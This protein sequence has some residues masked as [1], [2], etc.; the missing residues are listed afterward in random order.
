MI[1][2]W[3][4]AA[5]NGGVFGAPLTD[6]S[7]AFDCI[8]HDL[9]IAKLEAYGFHI[10]ASQ[11]IHDYLSNRK[12]RVKVNDAYSSWKDIF[13]GVPQGS[14]LDPFSFDIHLC[15]LFYFLEDFDIASYADDTT[16]YKVS[17][18]EE[19]VI[20]AL[21]TSSSL[22]FGWFNNNFMKANSDKSN[23]IMSCAEAS[24]AV[25]DG[26]PI[27]SS[28]TEVLLGITIDH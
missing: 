25:I 13:Y 12:Q 17:E 28:K 4:K 16:I 24:A 20:R 23:L 19:S 11:L 1:E 22:L 8:P 6:L 21:E 10:D 7:K 9:I 14:I 18:K 27:D 5:D 2:K 3:K 15:D 26:L